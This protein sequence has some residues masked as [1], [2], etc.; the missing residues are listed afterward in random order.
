[1]SGVKVWARYAVP[2]MV[3]VD[4]ESD[5]IEKVV[6]VAGERDI[7]RARPSMEMLFYTEELE[8]ISDS[9]D[10]AAHALSVGDHARWPDV[11]DWEIEQ[12]W[13]GLRM[14]VD[15]LRHPR[16]APSSARNPTLSICRHSEPSRCAPPVRPCLRRTGRAAPCGAR[17]LL[18][19]W[20]DPSAVLPASPTG[21]LGT[22]RLRG[23]V[24]FGG[25][26]M[27]SVRLVAPSSGLN[28]S[29]GGSCT[30]TI[31]TSAPDA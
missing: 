30:C 18:S 16:G 22:W 9:R 10:E 25:R 17:H 11:C 29:S 21:L 28:A 14:V 6:L 5:E 27:G 24:R 20:A 1:V 2:V 4:E 23:V 8:L 26:L 19:C 15:E 13:D 7:D 12:S 3:L 31:D